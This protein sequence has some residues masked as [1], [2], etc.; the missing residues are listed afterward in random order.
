MFGILATSGHSATRQVM[1]GVSVKHQVAAS[2]TVLPLTWYVMGFLSVLQIIHLTL[3]L[4]KNLSLTN[5]QKDISV[6]SESVTSSVF[7]NM[8][9]NLCRSK[10]HENIDWGLRPSSI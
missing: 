3:G 2:D 4:R 1:F 6:L 9:G 10:A 8:V 7:F 5:K